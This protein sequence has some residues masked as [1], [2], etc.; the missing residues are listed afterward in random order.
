MLFRSL[1]LLP[2]AICYKF[3]HAVL[4]M[5]N[6]IVVLQ[7]SHDVIC[8]DDGIFA[9][10]TQ[11]L[12]TQHLDIDVSADQ[13][14]KVPIKTMDFANGSILMRIVKIVAVI[15]FGD[16]RHGEIGEELFYHSHGTCAGTTATMR[17]REGFVQVEVNNVES[18]F[19]GLTD[20]EQ[21]VE[22][23]PIHIYKCVHAVE[24]GRAS[25]RER[26]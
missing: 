15:V 18:T 10:S 26:V 22:I 14:A 7:M 16:H 24:I 11:S 21:G 20:A 6:V 2:T 19:S 1:T 8:I 9:G 12:T 23:C 5:L 13:D 3:V 25:C 17:G 4:R